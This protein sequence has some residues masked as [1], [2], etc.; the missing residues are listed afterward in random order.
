MKSQT[1]C[2]TTGQMYRVSSNSECDG[3]CQ[4][5]SGRAQQRINYFCNTRTS[6]W[7]VCVCACVCVCVVCVCESVCVA[8]VL[9]IYFVIPQTRDPLCYFSSKPV[10][11]DSCSKDRSMCYPVCGLGR[12]K[13]P[14]LLIERVSHVVGQRVSSLTKWS[15]TTIYLR[16]I[17][18]NKM[19]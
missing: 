4:E 14:L 16:H 17:N 15:F 6:C 1:S 7:C 8:H 11:H 18:V 5:L 12:I 2:T 3:R 9:F 13:E 10:L 19:R